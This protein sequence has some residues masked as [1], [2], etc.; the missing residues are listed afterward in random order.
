MK[1]DPDNT[2]TS[3]T[4]SAFSGDT[5]TIG[6]QDYMYSLIV[7]PDMPPAHWP[8]RSFDELTLQNLIELGQYR[9]DIIILGTGQQPRFLRQEQTLLLLEKGILIECMNNRAACGAYNLILAENRNAML[10][11]IMEE[12]GEIK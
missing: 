2:G 10:A 5:V 9:P 1:L 8:I 3:R 7:M 4:V 11:L 12:M 6:G